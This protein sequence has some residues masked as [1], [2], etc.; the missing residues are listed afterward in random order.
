MYRDVV[1][2]NPRQSLADDKRLEKSESVKQCQS[3]LGTRK[4]KSNMFFIYVIF[5][6]PQY[7]FTPE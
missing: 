2:V 5:F 4:K 1:A 6:L 7:C 3:I